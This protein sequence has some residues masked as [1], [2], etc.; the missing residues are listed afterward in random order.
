MVLHM[1]G[2]PATIAWPSSDD[3]DVEECF[4]R[5][6]NGP[7]LKNL[8]SRRGKTRSKLASLK[9]ELTTQAKVVEDSRDTKDFE[10]LRRIQLDVNRAT[11]RLRDFDRQIETYGQDT[12]TASEELWAI[13]QLPQVIGIRADAPEVLIVTVVA[14]VLVKNKPHPEGRFYH[15]GT[16][17]VFF[18]KVE[19]ARFRGQQISQGL[20]DASH[21][22]VR[23]SIETRVEVSDV[24][25]NYFNREDGSFCFG[26]T[27]T[28]AINEFAIKREFLHA[29]QMMITYMSW[30]G[31]GSKLE[32]VTYLFR[33]LEER[34]LRPC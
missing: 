33:P 25:N 10:S 26:T 5:I 7:S 34:D 32:S 31:S 12:A 18:G 15:L 3:M 16:W 24:G 13:R 6:K 20:G 17:E 21:F 8:R 30:V 14:S 29:L 4:A 2:E 11:R 9:R 28:S 22:R 23:R 19:E 1:F 27:N